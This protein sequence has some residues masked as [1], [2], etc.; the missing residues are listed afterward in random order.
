MSY[1]NVVPNAQANFLIHI[2]PQR[3]PPIL[4]GAR[5][6]G[7]GQQPFE[8][9]VFVFRNVEHRFE[10]C[11]LNTMSSANT[12]SK[13]FKKLKLHKDL[14]SVLQIIGKAAPL[15]IAKRSTFS[16]VG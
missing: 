8:D 10:G 13:L 14:T 9:L 2:Y 7:L 11:G 1:V 4:R 16:Y 5:F 15:T 3:L 12:Q 6:V